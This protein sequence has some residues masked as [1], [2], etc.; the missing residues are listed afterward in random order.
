MFSCFNVKVAF[1][2][3]VINDVAVDTIKIINNTRAELF[4][5]HFFNV[6]MVDSFRYRF[7]NDF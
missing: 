4:R 3:A 7:G 2:F 5:K 1:C 6:D